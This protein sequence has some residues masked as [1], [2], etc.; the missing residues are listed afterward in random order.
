MRRTRSRHV[1]RSVL[2]GATTPNRNGL[3][4][5][6][7]LSFGLSRGIDD[8][9]TRNSSVQPRSCTRSCERPELG[10]SAHLDTRAAGSPTNT[11]GT[12]RR[13]PAA[14]ADAPLKPNRR[15]QPASLLTQDNQVDQGL[16][17]VGRQPGVARWV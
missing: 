13:T 15:P 6:G 16:D 1:G 14:P 8:G 17:G 11:A 4:M 12:E 9:S 3:V 10:M 7:L 5:S 2:S